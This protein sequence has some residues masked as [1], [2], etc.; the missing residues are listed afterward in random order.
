MRI[1]AHESIQG[2]FHKALERAVADKCDSVQIFTKSP[3][4]WREPEVSEEQVAAFRKA[5]AA[6]GIDPVVVHA[7]YLINTCAASPSARIKAR[8]AL[9][10]EARRCDL[11]GVDFLVFHPGSPGDLGD[12]T[13]IR[14]T[15]ESV[16]EVLAESARVS[17]LVENTAG[18]GKGIGWRF[19]HLASILELAGG[20]A[21]LGVCIDT[22][23]AF[24]AGYDLE[25]GDAAEAVFAEL[26]ALLGC[27]RVRA[28]HVNDA[29]SERGSRVDRHELIGR[30]SLGF[31]VFEWLVNAPRFAQTPGIVETPVAKGE[32]Y[33]AE[34]AA[35]CALVKKKGR[36]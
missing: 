23:H 6:T 28:L 35:L 7:S 21:R 19:E 4:I 18:Q 24:A 29:K 11:L 17:I 5:R 27:D 30:G 16:R 9:V 25:S 1:G 8:A 2:G 20:D 34:V 12:D 36:R 10:A 3:Q 31:T 26:D 22:C 14:H 33:A 32:T 13:G 15:A